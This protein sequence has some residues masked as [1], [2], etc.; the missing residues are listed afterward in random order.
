MVLQKCYFSVLKL[1]RTKHLYRAKK[2]SLTLFRMYPFQSIFDQSYIIIESALILACSFEVWTFPLWFHSL[3]CLLN[4]MIP[5][6]EIFSVVYS[7]SFS[8][9]GLK[10]AV[11]FQLLVWRS[12]PLVFFL[13]R[14]PEKTNIYFSR[15]V[16]P[17]LFCVL[18]IL[19]SAVH[20][21]QQHFLLEV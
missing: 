14:Y 6:L 17:H 20:S 3:E 10:I 9:L 19:G 12:S 13:D 4:Q 11:V 1:N 16:V 8:V 18:N 21:Q 15:S 5:L 7:S 2:Q